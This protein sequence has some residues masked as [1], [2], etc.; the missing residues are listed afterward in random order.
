MGKNNTEIV[1]GEVGTA[2]LLSI[3]E[4]DP[5][6]EI[7]DALVRASDQV[8]ECG[9]IG[10]IER[11]AARLL[12]RIEDSIAECHQTK[13]DEDKQ[14]KSLVDSFRE[15]SPSQIASEPPGRRATRNLQEEMPWSEI[16][17]DLQFS[18][19]QVE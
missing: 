16:S 13:F 5:L 8:N 11:Q 15:V 14:R 4:N 18:E 3:D 1:D 6:E 2:Y 19:I 10:N 17:Y 12:C 7:K 9:Q